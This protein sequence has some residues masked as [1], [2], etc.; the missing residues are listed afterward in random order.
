MNSRLRPLFAAFAPILIAFV[1]VPGCARDQTLTG[2]Q[3]QPSA[4]ATF[5]GVDPA[6]FVN[7]KA[8]GSYEHPPQ[9]KDI[10]NQVTWESDTPLVVQIS[11][12]GVASPNTNC[13]LGNVFAIMHDHASGSDI[14]SNSAPI[15]VNGPAAL[16]CT[17]AGTQPVL[18]VTFAGTGTGT[19]TSSPSGISCDSSA[20][21]CGNTF[22]IGTNLTLIAT[23]TGTSTFGS[24]SGCNQSTGNTCSVFLQN[25]VTVTAT[26]N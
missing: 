22:T 24:W 25:N 9:T 21:T 7:F 2:I 23:P 3:I 4:G 1:F 26:F 18:T 6:L 5:G 20:T 16:G 8:I 14:V 11:N 13:G 12:A 19:V 17:P 15:T 10:T